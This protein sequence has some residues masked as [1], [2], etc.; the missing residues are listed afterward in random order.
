MN[1][2]TSTVSVFNY[3]MVTFLI[4]TILIIGVLIFLLYIVRKF[5]IRQSRSKYI[6]VIDS[7]PLGKSTVIYLLKL[8]DKY[9]FLACTPSSTEIIGKIESEE[10]I[11]EIEISESESFSKIFF[12]KIGKNFLKNQIDRLDRM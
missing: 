5:S 10:D 3:S 12:S 4:S 11:K 8:K 2:A 9:V 1:Q 7:M 6:K